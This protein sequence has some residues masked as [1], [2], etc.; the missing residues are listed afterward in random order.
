V[1]PLPPGDAAVHETGVRKAESDWITALKQHSAPAMSDALEDHFILVA[2]DGSTLGKEELIAMVRDGRLVV[3]SESIDDAFVAEY[4]NAAVMTGVMQVQG[5]R[6]GSDINGSYRFTDTWIW[7][8][9]KWKMAA[10][11]FIGLKE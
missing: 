8:S 4:G 2:P 3:Q 6:D 1:T 5:T 10:S 9:G 11:V 7:K